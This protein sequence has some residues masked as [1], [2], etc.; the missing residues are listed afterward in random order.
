M[1]LDLTNEWLPS[2]AV[3][4]VTVGV[5]IRTRPHIGTC[6][7]EISKWLIM[8][9]AARPLYL[10][11]PLIDCFALVKDFNANEDTK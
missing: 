11:R 4:L 9:L 8:A 10:Y 6:A 2:E 1:Q 3:C 7:V 5:L